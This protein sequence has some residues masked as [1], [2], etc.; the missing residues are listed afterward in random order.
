VGLHTIGRGN[1]GKIK[2]NAIFWGYFRDR[3]I[4]GEM[5][6][7]TPSTKRELRIGYLRALF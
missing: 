7:N 4:T 6:N 1:Q 2:R 3:Q 5:E